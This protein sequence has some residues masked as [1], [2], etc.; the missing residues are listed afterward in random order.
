[1]VR[2][3]DQ[4]T[5]ALFITLLHCACGAPSADLSENVPVDQSKVEVSTTGLVL[6]DGQRWKVSPHMVEP[7]R[8][9]QERIAEAETLP[10]DQRDHGALADS[11][12]VDIDQLVAAC[13][14]KGKAHDVLHEWLMPHM[15]LAQDLE[16]ASNPGVADS[17]LHALVLS[18]R[19]YD[20]YFE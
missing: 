10:V 1:M 17:L 5:A 15:Q 11:L 18:S 3:L 13:D 8:R 19:T 12:F 2:M 4:F 16:R 6:N 14:M 7:I 20:L 9:M